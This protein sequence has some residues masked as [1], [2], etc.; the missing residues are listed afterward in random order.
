MTLH[1]LPGKRSMWRAVREWYIVGIG[2]LLIAGGLALAAHQSCRPQRSIKQPARRQTRQRPLLKPLPELRSR[3]RPAPRAGF[4]HRARR[5]RLCRPSSLP[6]LPHPPHPARLP[7]R[8]RRHRARPPYRTITRRRAP[9]QRRAH[10]RRRHQARAPRAAAIPSPGGSCSENAKRATRS[11][12]ARIS[13][14]HRSPAS[15]AEKPAPSP[16]IP[17]RRR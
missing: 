3:R 11:N 16:A 2:L 12:P 7:L 10:K 4:P 15:S 1:C 8:R 14:A 17:I 13:S 6:Y 9:H 5:L